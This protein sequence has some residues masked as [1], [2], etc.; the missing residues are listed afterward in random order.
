MSI[1]HLT[2]YAP[3]RRVVLLGG[4]GF[5]GRHLL[6]HLRQLSVPVLALGSSSLNLCEPDAGRRL[7]E[8]L[9]PDDALII[10]AAITPDRGNTIQTLM[11]NLRMAEQCC[12]LAADR[13]SHLVYL[14]SDAIYGNDSLIRDD[15]VPAPMN[16]YAQA[17]FLREYLIRT[18]ADQWG[19]P[20][21]VLRPTGIYGPGDTHS[22]YGP[23]RFLKT[24]LA[25]K[26]IN[27]FGGGEELR[28]HIY[29]GDVVRLI[30]LSLFRR[31]AGSLNLATGRSH[32][33]SQVAALAADAVPHPVAIRSFPR[34]TPITHRHFDI[35]E[36]IRAFPTFRFT[37]LAEG[38][39]STAGAA[40]ASSAA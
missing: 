21:L 22:S 40:T 31:S 35:S 2:D 27:L 9:E 5:V 38:I 39:R 25:D 17:H 23:N 18:A 3:P 1:R 20:C 4:S 26:S 14:S 6:Q 34:R 32:T 36:L 10:A 29:V 8:Q 19:C 33:F 30:A 7:L 15:S 24:A 28:D 37:D 16:C 11:A 13:L 12:S